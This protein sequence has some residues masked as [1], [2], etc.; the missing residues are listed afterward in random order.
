MAQAKPAT[1]ACGACST[2]RP[3]RY[4]SGTAG[5]SRQRALSAPQ[6]LSDLDGQPGPAGPGWGSA[7]K[8]GPARGVPAWEAG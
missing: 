7:Q 2:T 3:G 8:Q 1:P 4:H 5:G 6:E